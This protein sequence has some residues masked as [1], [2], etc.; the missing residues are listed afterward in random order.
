MESHTTLAYPAYE[1][2][3]PAVQKELYYHQRD[4]DGIPFVCECGNCFDF[5]REDAERDRC[6]SPLCSDCLPIGLCFICNQEI[7]DSLP[8]ANLRES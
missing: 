4:E 3:P 7:N 5:T 1:A 8:E 2:L 6:E